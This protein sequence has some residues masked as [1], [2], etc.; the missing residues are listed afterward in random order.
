MRHSTRVLGLPLRLHSSNGFEVRQRGA[1]RILELC[2][3]EI[4]CCLVGELLERPLGFTG[5]PACCLLV[6]TLG[7]CAAF[8]APRAV[9]SQEAPRGCYESEGPRRAEL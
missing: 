1:S 8:F 4:I 5:K 3:I 6:A 9:R 7:C 2:R